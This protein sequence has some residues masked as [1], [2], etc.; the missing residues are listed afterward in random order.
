[1]LLNL[2]K[3]SIP[4]TSWAIWLAVVMVGELTSTLV[5][6][7]RYFSQQYYISILTDVYQIKDPQTCILR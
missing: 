5:L 2:K 3:L 1:M 6:I 7:A 4:L